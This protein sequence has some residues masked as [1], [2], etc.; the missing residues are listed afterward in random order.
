ME[1]YWGVDHGVVEKGLGDTLRQKKTQYHL[2]RMEANRAKFINS[3]DKGYEAQAAGQWN[4]TKRLGRKSE[5]A[6]FRTDYHEHKA[7]PVHVPHPD[8]RWG[9]KQPGAYNIDGTISKRKSDYSGQAMGAGATV[10]GVGLVGG[11]VPI[12]RPDSGR[13]HQA[14]TSHSKVGATRHLVSGARGG[15]FGYREDAHRKYLNQMNTDLRGWRA[16]NKGKAF[17]RGAMQGRVQA[18]KKVI[19]TMHGA[20][21]GSNVA[22]GGGAALAAGG[23]IAHKRKQAVAKARKNDEFKSN[24]LLGGGGTLAAAGFAGGHAM[25]A[26]GNKWAHRAKTHLNEAHA[27]NPNLGGYEKE[28]TPAKSPFGRKRASNVP[29]IH[30]SRSTQDIAG[31]WQGVFHGHSEANATKAGKLRGQAT[32][33]RYFSR[34]Y[35]KQAQVARKAGKVGLGIAA[36][37]VAGRSLEVKMKPGARNRTNHLK[38]AFKP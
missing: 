25:D 31:N 13:L 36:A 35:G 30:P 6:A 9:K 12:A 8:V 3:A 1:S 26:Q 20:R 10:A 16:E 37:G 33:E 27:L 28:K 5:K 23:L 19:R 38:Q 21:L 14:K 34:V 24:A 2:N 17:E 22:L 15:I 18:E 7:D 11:G 4:K 32:Q 29:N